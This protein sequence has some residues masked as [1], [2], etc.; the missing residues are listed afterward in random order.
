MLYNMAIYE[1]I[2]LLGVFERNNLFLIRKG[3]AKINN[4]CDTL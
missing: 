4:L 3:F 2:F 1:K